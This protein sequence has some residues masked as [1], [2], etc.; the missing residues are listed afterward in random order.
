MAGRNRGVGLGGVG[1]HLIVEMF[2]CDGRLL[3]SLEVV[4]SALLDAAVASNSTVVGFDFY[5]FKPHGISG[6]VLV[7]ESHISIH[8]WPEYGYAA[9][10][11]FTCGEHTDPWKGLEILKE[12]L[13]AKK[14]TIISIE[15]GVGIENYAGYWTPTREK[16][17]AVQV[18]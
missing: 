3:D 2:E 11:V 8:T 1:R 14:V 4:K 12:R 5:R 17:Q 15:R 10:D 7:A 9:V 18:H 13:R 6:Y 16:E